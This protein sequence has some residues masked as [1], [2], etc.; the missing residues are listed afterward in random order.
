LVVMCS[1]HNSLANIDC[2]FRAELQRIF[3]TLAVNDRLQ[4]QSLSEFFDQAEMH[5]THAE[6]DAAFNAAFGGF[7]NVV[8][9]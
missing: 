3:R 7:L 5:P 9:S 1:N 4:K 2:F 8:S 6:V